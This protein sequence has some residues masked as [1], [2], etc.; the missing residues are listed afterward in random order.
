MAGGPRSG[1]DDARDLRA[2]LD[3]AF[4]YT[5]NLGKLSIMLEGAG[6]DREAATLRERIRD[7][8]SAGNRVEMSL[9]YGR[10][11]DLLDP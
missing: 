2:L 8:A 7:I 9:A 10:L 1:S 3:T 11:H 5:R 6:L 4:R